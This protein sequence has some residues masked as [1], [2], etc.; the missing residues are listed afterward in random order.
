[1]SAS[2]EQNTKFKIAHV[3]VRLPLS[4]FFAFSYLDLFVPYLDLSRDPYLCVDLDL[5]NHLVCRQQ[6][7][8]CTFKNMI[9]SN[10]QQTLIRHLK[11]NAQHKETT[12]Y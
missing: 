11:L 6:N 2:D 8:D 12:W 5:L 4:D 10:P 7:T 1:M 3:S 9:I